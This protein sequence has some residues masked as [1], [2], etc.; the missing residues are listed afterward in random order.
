MGIPEGKGVGTDEGVVVGTEVGKADGDS[1]GIAV[2]SD[3]QTLEQTYGSSQGNF[4]L[5]TA[6]SLMGGVLKD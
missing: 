2:G 1:V 5:L 3:V 6:K 4:L